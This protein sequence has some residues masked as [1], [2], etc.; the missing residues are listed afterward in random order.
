MKFLCSG[1]DTTPNRSYR[2]RRTLSGALCEN[3]RAF[4]PAARSICALYRLTRFGTALPTPP[5]LSW[6]QNPVCFT[7]CPLSLYPYSNPNSDNRIPTVRL[8]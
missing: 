7:A 4:P 1:M 5:Q 3:R 8:A 6:S 2:S